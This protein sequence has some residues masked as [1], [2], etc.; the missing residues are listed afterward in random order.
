MAYYQMYPVHAAE[1]WNT[2][3]KLKRA[4]PYLA[5]WGMTKKDVLIFWDQAHA[6]YG[7]SND[8]PKAKTYPYKPAPSR[9]E[10]ISQYS[11]NTGMFGTYAEWLGLSVSYFLR[12][13]GYAP[14]SEAEI[15]QYRCY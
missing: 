15:K 12:E 5:Q 3:M 6:R 11:S 8:I 4:V 13:A 2:G 9:R 14:L 10:L 7:F 1:A